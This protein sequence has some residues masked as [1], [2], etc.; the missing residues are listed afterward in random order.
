MKKFNFKQSQILLEKSENIEGRIKILIAKLNSLREDYFKASYSI[1]NKILSLRK[2]Q[3][4]GYGISH[5]SKE[6]GL[7]LTSH[8]IA[9]IFGY[10]HISPFVMEKIEGGQLKT[11]TALYIIKQSTKFRKPEYQDKIVKMYLQ[12]K[13]DTSQISFMS[14]ENILKGVI[15]DKEINQADKLAIRILNYY[16][17][18]LKELRH[19][20]D[21]FKD[22]NVINQIRLCG[23]RIVEQSER[24]LK[25]GKNLDKER[26]IPQNKNNPYKFLDGETNEN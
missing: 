18:G 4:K 9:Y 22:R 17:Q 20:E 14:A 24:I 11:S 6:K 23:E 13:I 2:T 8:Q 26:D 19:R 1:L 3:I 25:F 10:R 16:K 21:L 12:R 5:L 7:N 15:S